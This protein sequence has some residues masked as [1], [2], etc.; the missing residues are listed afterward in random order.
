MLRPC[1][2]ATYYQPTVVCAYA[3]DRRPYVM[4]INEERILYGRNVMRPSF[5]LKIIRQARRCRELRV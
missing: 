4:G 1:G 2:N 5:F 3:H